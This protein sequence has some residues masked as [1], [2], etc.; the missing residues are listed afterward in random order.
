MATNYDLLKKLIDGTITRAQYEQQVAARKAAAQAG[1]ADTRLFT[2]AQNIQ[3][4]QAAVAAAKAAKEAVIKMLPQADQAAIKEAE[5]VKAIKNIQ[6]TAPAT[7]VSAETGFPETVQEPQTPQE[8]TITIYDIDGNARSVPE[9]QAG[10]LLTLKPKKFFSSAADAAAYKE[11]NKPTVTLYDKNGKPVTGIDPNAVDDMLGTG[12]FFR[13]PQEAPNY[14]APS[15]DGGAT[16]TGGGGTGA[17][18]WGRYDSGSWAISTEE[19][20]PEGFKWGW[21]LPEF[22]GLEQADFSSDKSLDEILGQVTDGASGPA[23]GAAGGTTG[24]VTGVSTG[25]MGSQIWQDQSGQKYLVFS[26]PGTNMFVRYKASDDDLASFFTTGMPDV[27]SINQDAEDWNNSLWLGSYVEIDGDIKLGLVNPFDTMVDNFAKVKKVQPWMEEDELYSLWLEGIIE[28]RDIEDYEWQGTEWWQTHTKEQRD[29]LLTSQ[30][31]GL[32]SLPA[33]AQALLDNNKIRAKEL[34]KQYGVTNAEEIIN[35]DGDT[36]VDFFANQLTVGNWTELTWANQAKGLGD[37][38]AGI[39]R[40]TQLTNWLD[41]ID[42]A[43]TPATTQAGYSTAQSLA[44]KWLGPTFANFEDTNLAEYAGMI[45]NAESQEVGI[46]AVENRLK[47][48]RKAL[49]STDLYDENLTYEDIAAPWRNYSYQ[50]LGQRMDETA[51]EWIN[52]LKANDQEKI[53]SI[54]LEYGLNNNVQ[55]L[56][57]RVTDGI[58]KGMT[59]QAVVRGLPT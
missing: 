38:L 37:P 29:W 59:P 35:A 53:N 57:D 54:L 40:D 4:E 17:M 46:A 18:Y 41:N 39:E 6:A 49:F 48:I 55:T 44:L 43:L 2:A 33:D 3:A 7:Q 9:S 50:F 16:G 34:L 20:K 13:T 45:R 56:F 28:D 25:R 8:N 26:I 14:T 1:A 12:D 24:G 10:E 51:A 21:E 36:L 42:E 15:G 23:G 58:F 22:A 19:G 11:K 30:G 32:G 47:A 52:V 27:R 5:L 31:K